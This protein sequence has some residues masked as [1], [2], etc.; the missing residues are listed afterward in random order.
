ML[1]KQLNSMQLLKQL[2]HLG[3]SLDA[4]VFK[5]LSVCWVSKSLALI[6]PLPHYPMN[7]LGRLLQ[8]DISQFFPGKGNEKAAT[9]TADNICI[10]QQSHQ[11]VKNFWRQFD[12]VEIF[13]FYQGSQTSLGSIQSGD[14]LEDSLLGGLTLIFLLQICNWC[15]FGL[16]FL[17]HRYHDIFF[18]IFFPIP[19]FSINVYLK[20]MR[21]FWSWRISTQEKSQN[22]REQETSCKYLLIFHLLSLEFDASSSDF[23]QNHFRTGMSRHKSFSL[24]TLT[25]A[26]L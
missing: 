17:I 2:I 10:L 16:I 19:L 5:A 18:N 22:I 6:P 11:G 8:I 14:F 21:K 9:E 7:W 26:W 1:L 25:E 23:L 4:L 12:L 24:P 15:I 13:H 3:T 20:A